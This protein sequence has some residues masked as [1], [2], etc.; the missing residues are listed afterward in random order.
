DAGHLDAHCRQRSQRLDEQRILSAVQQLCGVSR[1]LD[2]L[3]AAGGGDLGDAALPQAQGG[4]DVVVERSALAQRGH[5]LGARRGG[6]QWDCEKCLDSLFRRGGSTQ[7]L[8]L[9][10]AGQRGG[11]LVLNKEPRVGAAQGIGAVKV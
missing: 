8:Q 9:R 6:R 3:T 5:C 2:R 11:Q 10:T 1:L 7:D 4:V